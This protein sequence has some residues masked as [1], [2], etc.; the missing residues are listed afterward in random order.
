VVVGGGMA[1]L[2]VA[3]QLA[4]AGRSVVVLE[5]EKIGFGASG[6]NGGFVSPG[7]ATDGEAIARTT[8]A[9]KARQLHRLSIEGVDFVRDT[10]RD[11]EIG[12]AG[13]VNGITSVLRQPGGAAEL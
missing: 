7:F 1:G 12:D 4:R 5:A 11:L 3:L 9:E 2:T 8:G 13:V 10:I 6:R